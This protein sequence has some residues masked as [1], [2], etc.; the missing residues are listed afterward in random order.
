MKEGYEVEIHM[1]TTMLIQSMNALQE[2]VDF[3][4]VLM[5]LNSKPK[6]FI[7]DTW[8]DNQPLIGGKTMVWYYCDVLEEVNCK[9][10]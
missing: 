7:L 2:A 6:N 9:V 5:S 3:A 1:D 8:I 4:G 10:I